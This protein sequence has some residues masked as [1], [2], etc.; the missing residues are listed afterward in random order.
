V[1][2]GIATAT[3][4]LAT[5]TTTVTKGTFDFD[6][7]SALYDP[8]PSASNSPPR[9]YFVFPH[10]GSIPSSLDYTVPQA[11]LTTVH[12]HIY[13]EPPPYVADQELWPDVYLPWGD[14]EELATTSEDSG[15]YVFPG[16]HT[17]YWYSS[18][19]SLTAWQVSYNTGICQGVVCGGAR[20]WGQ[21]RVIHPG[22]QISETWDKAPSAVPPVAHPVQG[23]AEFGGAGV[24]PVTDAQETVCPA[25]RQG[26]I[27]MLYLS[28]PADSSPSHYQDADAGM[29]VISFYRNGALAIDSAS[30]PQPGG[31]QL[32]S[33]FGLELPLLAQPATYQLDWKPYNGVGGVG[34]SDLIPVTRT[35]WSFRSGPAGPVA[36][37][38]SEECAPDPAQGCSFLP[39]LYLTYDLNLNSA[40]QAVAGSPFTVAFSVGYQP[41][42]A[43]P[44]GVKATVAASFDDGQTWTSPQSAT[45]Q[46][47]NR[48]A[49]AID[50][51]ALSGTSGFV[52]LR[53]TATDGAGNSVTQT[54]IR[55]YGL[56]S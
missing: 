47:G 41:G 46:G 14:T 5:P 2:E 34:N 11:D 20:I 43:A 39:L 51:P 22:Q 7:A 9:Y 6:A 27:G 26:N 1:N 16:E 38:T 13:T 44:S 17:D 55:A 23:F 28:P 50:Q 32:L 24:G 25:C 53:V 49:A 30:L 40:S 3:G 48:F 19:P 33:P 35:D 45:A 56:T 4:L 29:G 8:S 21:R 15:T 12:E 54:I 42:E 52:S 10:P 37:P 36:L 31:L 18:A